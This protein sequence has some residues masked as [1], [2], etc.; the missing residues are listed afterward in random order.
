MVTYSEVQYFGPLMHI[1]RLFVVHTQ[2][3][4]PLNCDKNRKYN[5]TKNGFCVCCNMTPCMSEGNKFKCVVLYSG[6][7][8]SKGVRIAEREIGFT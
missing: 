7:T 3:C 8:S 4:A 2:K 5:M 6:K 1:V